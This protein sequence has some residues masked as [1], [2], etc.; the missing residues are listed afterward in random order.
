MKKSPVHTSSPIISTP[1]YNN[2]WRN[3]TQQ[4]AFLAALL[5]YLEDESLIT[6]EAFQGLL[7][8]KMQDSQF[9]SKLRCIF[10]L[11][12]FFP[13]SIFLFAFA[14]RSGQSTRGGLSH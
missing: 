3:V 13:P 1:R 4:H 9:C 8:G 6:F 7:G 14:F 2:Q 11:T 12:F 10:M 5:I